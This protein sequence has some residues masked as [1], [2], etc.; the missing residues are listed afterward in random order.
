[1][2]KIKLLVATLAIAALAIGLCACS[3][4]GSVGKTDFGW[5]KAAVPQG[6]TDV[7]ESGNVGQKFVNDN[8]KDQI[9]K[10]YKNSTTSTKANAAAAKADRISKDPEKYKDKGQIKMGKY[11]WEAIGYTWNGDKQSLMLFADGDDKN[12]V[13][14]DFF[15]M[16][17]N[18]EQTKF[19]AE[20]FEYVGE[21]EKK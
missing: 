1:M 11:N 18:N 14:L 9:I 17:E 8:D 20:S 21:Q 16:D 6:F 12:I 15:C 2:K 3:C 13:Q 10:V 19:F 7:K 4:S 5:Y